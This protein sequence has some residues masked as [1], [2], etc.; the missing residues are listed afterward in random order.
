MATSQQKQQW[1]QRRE[2]NQITSEN[3]FG[4]SQQMSLQKFVRTNVVDHRA[5]EFL[6]CE[7]PSGRG[8]LEEMVDPRKHE[9]KVQCSSCVR[10]HLKLECF[11]VLLPRPAS[12]RVQPWCPLAVTFLLSVTW[13][14]WT[15]Q[16]CSLVRSWWYSCVLNKCNVRFIYIVLEWLVFSLQSGLLNMY[17]IVGVTCL[18]WFIQWVIW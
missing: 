11:Q 8:G 17:F 13:F 1:S 2:Q 4:T 12:V 3:S 18:W 10:L 16:W 15:A 9:K 14:R 7:H 6:L 5:L